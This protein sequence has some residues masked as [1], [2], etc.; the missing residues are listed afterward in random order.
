M[1]VPGTFRP[2]FIQSASTKPIPPP[3]GTMPSNNRQ[4]GISADAAHTVSTNSA[5]PA[6][7]TPGD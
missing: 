7:L 2:V 4:L 3:G 5:Q 1:A 6:I